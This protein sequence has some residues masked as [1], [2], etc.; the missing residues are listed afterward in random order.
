MKRYQ[1][2]HDAFRVGP[3]PFSDDFFSPFSGNFFSQP[4]TSSPSAAPGGEEGY[5][6]TYHD[7]R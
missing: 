2:A 4:T 5:A 3:P 6:E 1:S 7:R